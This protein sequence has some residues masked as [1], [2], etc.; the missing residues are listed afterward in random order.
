MDGEVGIVAFVGEE[1]GD[2][3]GSI[4]SI[5]V[6]ELRKRQELGPIVLLIVGIYL[7]IL[8]KHLVH[9][10]GLSISFRVVAGGEVETD[11]KGLA[12]GTEEMGNKLRTPVRGDVQGNSM[13]RK[14]IEEEQLC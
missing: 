3:H 14:H 5:I 10:L 12:Q 2:T 8:L 7:Q 13:F 11:I 9:S 1:G 6:C 4:R